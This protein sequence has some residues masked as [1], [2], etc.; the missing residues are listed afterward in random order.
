MKRK[1]DSDINSLV[2]DIQLINCFDGIDEW[3]MLIESRRLKNNVL[4]MNKNEINNILKR[5]EQR[6]KRYIANVDMTNIDNIKNNIKN[7]IKKNKINKL[8][9]NKDTKELLD[10][11]FE[12]DN[13]II[14]YL[15]NDEEKIKKSK[16]Y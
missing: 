4:N 5:T 3:R 2:E 11:M 16:T 13:M 14:D 1:Y 7:F 15:D 6:Y 10:L 8:Q 12:T 9:Y